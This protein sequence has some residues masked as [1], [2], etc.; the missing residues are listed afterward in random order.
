MTFERTRLLLED[1]HPDF[2]GKKTEE[3]DGDDLCRVVPK[4]Y[5]IIT[6]GTD[7]NA[8]N[9]DPADGIIAV[10]G[11]G[12]SVSKIWFYNFTTNQWMGT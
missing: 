2:F 11:T 5:Q 8:V 1:L 6:S 7:P 9:L 3:V 4:T 12:T 10:A